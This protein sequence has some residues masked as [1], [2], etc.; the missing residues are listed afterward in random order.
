MVR[1]ETGLGG[2]GLKRKDICW[3][4]FS[5]KNNYTPTLFCLCQLFDT[6]FLI[7]C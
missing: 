5:F 2:G 7:F 6:A 1:E 4:Y 3:V